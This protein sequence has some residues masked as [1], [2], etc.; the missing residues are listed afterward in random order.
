M[1]S[2]RR[3]HGGRTPAE[4]SGEH[5]QRLRT[6]RLSVH[7][8]EEQKLPP[9]RRVPHTAAE[10]AVSRHANLGPGRRRTSVARTDENIPN[11][12]TPPPLRIHRKS[13]PENVL[14]NQSTHGG[15]PAKT[16]MLP[17]P[18][19]SERRLSQP[20]DLGQ[21]IPIPLRDLPGNLVM[22]NWSI[23]TYEPTYL[24]RKCAEYF[25]VDQDGVIRPEDTF[26]GFRKLG[27]GILSS[28]FAMFAIHLIFSYPTCSGY[29]PD[30][31]SRIYYDN[32]HRSGF[33]G[34]KTSYDE[35]GRLRRN[36]AC[37]SILT[38]YDKSNKGGLAFRDLVHFWNEQR[39]EY[40]VY[41]WNIAVFEWLTLYLFLWPHNGIMR[42][43]DIRAAFNGTLLYKNAEERHQK[44]E[45][46]RKHVGSGVGFR[47]GRRSNP[48]KLAV[49]VI[50]GIVIIIWGLRNIS[51]TPSSWTTHWWKKHDSSG[52]VSATDP[53]FI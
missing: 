30:L 7:E 52:E 24:M 12:T 44:S 47:N 29:M 9:S 35:K 38:K 53:G 18:E 41:G 48:V 16:N 21:N 42:S 31:H 14:L 13:L 32:T 6:R 20:L 28:S 39:A 50:T 26:K 23:T 22:G 49:A 4:E 15:G 1:D 45:I 3:S 25:D 5:L 27:W 33:G 43:E 11:D 37:E 2:R 8:R 17:V 10:I 19:R 51:Q 46:H 34:Y 40:N 36:R